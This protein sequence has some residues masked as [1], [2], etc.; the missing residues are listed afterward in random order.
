M[1]EQ[2][3]TQNALTIYMDLTGIIGS[4]INTGIQR[5][6]KEFLQ[7]TLLNSGIEFQ[8]NNINYCYLEYNLKSKSYG[9]ISALELDNFLKN[10][11]EYQFA[12][13]QEIELFK[14]QENELSIFFD[15]DS[16]WNIH[17]KRIHLYPELKKNNYTI[18]NYL[19]DLS[20]VILPQYSHENTCRNFI[21]FLTAAYSYTDMVFFDSA[22]AEKNF[23]NIKKQL[24][25]TR[26]IP[27]RVTGLG[28]DF[29]QQNNIIKPNQ[30]L[31]AILDKKYILFVGTIE[32]RKDQ[33]LVLDAFETLAK[34]Y[35]D[36]N[37]VL[38]GKQ[39]WKV[40]EFIKRINNH[41]LKDKQFYYLNDIDDDTLSLFYQ[42]AWIVIYL[43]K[44]E[45]YGLPIAESLRHNNITIAS[46]NSS[47]YEV[48]KNYSD[49]IVYNSQN[50]IIDIISLYYDNPQLYQEKKQL[51][52]NSFKPASWDSF[53]ASIMEIFK[54]LPFSLQL[55]QQ[56]LQIRAKQKLQFV[57][58]SLEIETLQ[59]TIIAIDKY[60][61]FVK[62]YIVITSTQKMALVQAIKAQKKL[63]AIDEN[64]LLN[65]YIKDGAINFQQRDHVQKN[66]LLRASL[67]SIKELDENFI[68]LDDDNRPLKELDIDYFIS[69]QGRYNAY[70]FYDLLNWHSNTTDYDKGQ[71]NLHH[72]LSEK[73]YELLSYSS[74]APQ[75]INKTLYREAIERF[76]HIG[77]EKSIDEWSIYFNSSVSNYPFLFNK[78]VFETLNWPALPTD[79]KYQ[80]EPEQYSFENYYPDIYAAEDI[81]LDDLRYFRKQYTLDEKISIKKKKYLPHRVTYEIF[82]KYKHYLADKNHIFGCIKFESQLLDCYLFNIPKRLITMSSAQLRLEMNC[83]IINKSKKTQQIEIYCL[84]KGKAQ[85]SI[86]LP[87]PEKSFYETIIEL[88]ISTYGML[89]KDYSLQIDIKVNQKAVYDKKSPYKIKL[90]NYNYAYQIVLPKTI[91]K[92]IISDEPRIDFKRNIK[93]F[94]KEIPYLGII[95]KK[96]YRWFYPLQ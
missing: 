74:H 64:N 43:S 22:S 88:P 61:P 4:R 65:D 89:R 54:R 73:N 31:K 20:P 39:G 91:N 6:V 96:I 11:K 77:L 8:D 67:L 57:F 17:P 90:C 92:I 51:I 47:M 19:Y 23:L 49:Y 42:N 1:K 62:E 86:A 14:P 84:K 27:T 79:W 76:F 75:I 60:I 37:L 5:V 45:G 70:Y 29:S 63:I 69:K 12:D 36:L 93:H 3:K 87:V 44:H 16:V 68:M 82:D 71:H 13:V 94:I 7:R 34:K 10:I 33:E 35:S 52:K 21:S 25:V 41:P 83:K 66:W 95:S 15:M 81:S 30:K 28:S 80:Y 18:I 9:L 48:G 85:H 32:P 26:E 38:I 56:S 40:E 58:I 46:K 78:K 59:T 55:K 50:E 53:S 24:E 2:C 72:V